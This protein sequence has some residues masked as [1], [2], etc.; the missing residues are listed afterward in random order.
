MKFLRLLGA[1]LAFMACSCA[2][3]K[4]DV[5]PVPIAE[6]SAADGLE[7]RLW[8]VEDSQGSLA[9]ALAPYERP[10]SPIDGRTLM[11]LKE[12][13]L[14]ALVVPTAD[15]DSLAATLRI[16][17]TVE[18]QA[19]RD[20]SEWSIFVASKG[21]QNYATIRSADGNLVLG[22]GQ[23]L[24]LGRAWV[25]PGPFE[26]GKAPAVLRV[27]LM[28]RHLEQKDTAAKIED[29][30]RPEL[31]RPI[32][33]EGLSLKSLGGS[34]ELTRGQ[35]LLL[36]PEYPN[37]DWARDARL[38]NYIEKEPEKT[39]E[40]AEND[41]YSRGIGPDAPDMPTLGHALLSDALF[42]LKPKRRAILVLVP[43]L[44]NEFRL[45]R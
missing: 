25:A 15:L 11:R 2:A 12:S 23:L 36:V 27:E 28:G 16:R 3:R 22:G 24:L 10:D 29:A 5:K 7:L 21:W 34:F 18:T 30:L 31:R 38:P 4:D 17:G 40:A 41:P 32:E 14:R 26:N 6:Q 44:P 42:G 20:R 19:S 39:A 13:G 8:P 37:T 43:R 45:F 33:E 35:S 9:R 1:S